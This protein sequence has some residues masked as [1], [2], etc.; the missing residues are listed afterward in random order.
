MHVHNA[1]FIFGMDVGNVFGVAVALAHTHPQLRIHNQ[2]Q[3]KAGVRTC[4]KDFQGKNGARAGIRKRSVSFL[5][6]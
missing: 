3:Y 6:Q 4:Q 5:N 2:S 1:D